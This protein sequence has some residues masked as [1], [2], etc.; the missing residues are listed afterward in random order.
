MHLRAS[1]TGQLDQGFPRSS[2]VQEQMLSWLLSMPHIQF[3]QCLNASLTPRLS[4]VR[5]F[6]T[7][8]RSTLSTF[9]FLPF[10]PSLPEGRLGTAWEPS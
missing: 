4:A 10:D 8:H 6:S 2:S 7:S 5:P 3:S 9:A 1:A